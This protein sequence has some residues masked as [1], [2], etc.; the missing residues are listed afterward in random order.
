MARN[1]DS[2]RQLEENPDVEI[3]AFP[4]EVLAGLKTL[5][6]EVIED[7]AARDERVARVWESYRS[8]L[9]ASEPWQRISEQA[10]LETRS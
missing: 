3:L 8:F 5:T 1:A 9:E 7:L 10:Y 4:D 6:F 2:L